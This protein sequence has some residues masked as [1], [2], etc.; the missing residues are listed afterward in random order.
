MKSDGCAGIFLDPPYVVTG[1]RKAKVYTH[2]DG[3]S[4]SAAVLEY[5]LAHT[6][7]DVRIVLAGYDGDYPG[8]LDAGWREVEWFRGGFLKGGMGNVGGS[9]NHQQNR[10]RLYL[11]PQCLP[12]DGEQGTNTQIAMWGDK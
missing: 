8:L 6:H 3:D 12:V 10:E 5:C 2:D 7:D 1:S 9:G 4:V 11:S